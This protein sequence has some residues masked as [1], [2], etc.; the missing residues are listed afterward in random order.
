MGLLGLAFRGVEVNR[1]LGD[2]RDGGAIEV[3]VKI[4]G[5]QWDGGGGIVGMYGP[6]VSVVI[7]I[8]IIIIIKEG[9]YFA[10]GV[11]E[12]LDGTGIAGSVTVGGRMTGRE[13]LARVGSAVGSARRMSWG[14]VWRSGAILKM[15]VV[16]QTG[17]GWWTEAPYQYVVHVRGRQGVRGQGRHHHRRGQGDVHDRSRV[18]RGRHWVRRGRC[19]VRRVHLYYQ[20]EE[21]NSK[22]QNTG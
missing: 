22:G 12:V 20:N 2:D 9:Y 17:G 10:H 6:N 11:G 5:L 14:V 21:C 16:I 13:M 18:R 3:V 8:I 19:Q 7:S 4:V 1:A 15:R